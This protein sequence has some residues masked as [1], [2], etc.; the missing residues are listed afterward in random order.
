[1]TKQ[2][3]LHNQGGNSR[4]AIVGALQK[5]HEAITVLN[6]YGIRTEEV[7]ECDE[8]MIHCALRDKLVRGILDELRRIEGRDSVLLAC[9][10]SST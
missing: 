4:Q 6:D 8:G 3:R 7:E 1:M 10:Y 2:D 5:M 9:A